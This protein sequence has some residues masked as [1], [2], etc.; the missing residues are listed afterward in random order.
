MA[1]KNEP[2]KPKAKAKPK[3]KAAPAT[4]ATSKPAGRNYVSQADVPR[5]TIEEALRIPRAIA[6]H[7]GKQPTRPLD[8]AAA[9]NMAPTTGT[10]RML[11][12]ASIAY[13]FTEG[14]PN[15]SSISITELGLRVVAPTLEGDDQ[16]AKREAVLRPRVVREFLEKYDG[17]PLPRADIGQNVLE[18]M[19][20]AASATERTL[21]LIVE[22]ADGLGLLTEINGKKYVNLQSAHTA[23]TDTDLLYDEDAD[24]DE[25][26]ALPNSLTAEDVAVA[27]RIAQPQAPVPPAVVE[28]ALKPNR[29]VFISH[30]KNKKVVAQLKELL[31]Y[32]DFEP[33]VSV[34]HE[35]ISK[36]VPDK[37]MDD[38]R[39]CGAGI[40]HVGTERLVKD[41]DGNEYKMVNQNVLIEIGAAMALYAGRFILLVE[42]GTTLP[43]NLQGLYEVR[44]EGEG[45]DHDST[46]KLLKAFN[47]FKG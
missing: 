29:R 10:F 22:S 21:E 28:E 43:S 40:I 34:E 4:P 17:S 27:K 19:G 13:G 5:H 6:E 18:A 23:A 15:A 16:T 25:Q 37:V 41:E 2:A 32:G 44:F 24:T 42:K 7:Y 39:S 33:V 47:D 3:P 38:M 1:S 46:M 12:G 8:V 14:G 36:P 20:V 30:G 9:M 11:A 26:A 35:T 31:A 45:L